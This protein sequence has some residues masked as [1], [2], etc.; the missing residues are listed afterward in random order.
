MITDLQ[1]TGSLLSDPAI[2]S[3][4][5]EQFAETTN[6]GQEGIETF[7]TSPVAHPNCNSEICKKIGLCHPLNPDELVDED[8]T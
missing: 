8:E 3:T 5:M 1:G 7:F 6:L 2:H 4:D